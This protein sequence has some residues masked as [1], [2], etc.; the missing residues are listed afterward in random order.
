MDRIESGKFRR[1]LNKLKDEKGKA[2]I[3]SRINRLMEG[4]PGDV[5]PVSQGISELRIHDG[6]G[7]RMYFHPHGNKAIVLLAGGD[8]STQ[9]RDIKTARRILEDWKSQNG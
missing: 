9:S 7:Y 4:L 3:V 2:K 6:P 1:W 8:K 5:A